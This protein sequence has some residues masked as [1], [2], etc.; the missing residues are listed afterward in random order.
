MDREE[1][2]P[3][4]SAPRDG[5]M[6]FSGYSDAQ[7]QQLRPHIDQARFPQDYARL[8]A[9]IARRERGDRGRRFAVRFTAAD[10]LAGW[11]QALAIRQPFYGAGT[12]TPGPE[13]I[14]VEGWRRTWLGL[15]QQAEAVIP[16]ARVRNVYGDQDWICFDVQR[17]AWWPRH[18]AARTGDA[19][20]AAALAGLLPATRSRWFEKQTAS[21]RDY[22]RLQRA[23]GR[24][25]LVTAVLVLASVLIYLIQAGI[26][27]YW[28]GLDRNTLINWGSNAG[29]YTVHGGWWRLVAALFLHLDPL[30]LIVNMWVLWSSGRLVERLFGNW[31]F[32]AIYFA[33]GIMGNLLSI[34]WNPAIVTVGASGAIFGVLGAYVAYLLHGD[35]RIPRPVMRAHLIPTVLF[36]FFSIL[37]G[38]GQSGIDNAAHFGG[39]GTGLLLGW[40]LARPLEGRPGGLRRAQGA[41]ALALTACAAVGL[42]LQVTGPASRPSAQEQFLQ[43][44]DWY[45]SGEARNLLAWQQIANQAGA[46]TIASADLA[47]RFRTEIIPF[48]QSTEPRLRKEVPAATPPARPFLQAVAD[49][50]AL[51][52]RWARAI[53]ASANSGSAQEAVTL[54][55]KTDAAQARLDW[56]VLRS[57]YD[58]R[59]LSL[60]AAPA[61]TLVANL[62]WFNYLPCIRSPFRDFNPVAPTDLSTDGPAQRLAL[63]CQAQRLFRM[64]DFT[65]LEAMMQDAHR[66]RGDLADGTSSYDAMLAG[67]G[68]LLDFGGLSVD[69]VFGRLAE[70][71]K[72]V[73]GSVNADLVEAEAL[74]S[75]AYAA[76]GMGFADSV[77]AQNQM[78]FQHRINIADAALQ[79]LEPRARDYPAWYAA[80]INV[81]LLGDGEEEERRA[82][83]ERARSRFPDDLA[84]SSAMLHALMPR[85]QGSFEKVAKFILEQ[86]ARAPRGDP[87]AERYARLYWL[88]AGLEGAQADIFKDAFARPEL[89]TLGMALAMKRFPKSDYL[90][91]VDG[92]LACQSDQRGEYLAFHAIMPKHYSASAWSPDFTVADCDKKFG[93]K[94]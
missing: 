92:R 94:S 2:Q 86:A 77:T 3:G 35:T 43:S 6:D 88:Y 40:A 67:L 11:L 26:S 5:A 80:A 66:L 65:N 45:R 7:L 29:S 28:L 68:N 72:A 81:N 48:W 85:W 64:R 70:W 4:A 82:I 55:Q 42:L 74:V 22:Y 69:G 93:L 76:R 46:G 39:L 15:A 31:R 19:G 14:H 44:H 38:L 41:A 16:A 83:F 27:G 62:F 91:N 90:A 84:V 51:R 56:F 34:G 60:A 8:E 18:Y 75:W 36:V 1:D 24:R 17:R 47:R 23:P 30:H 57:Q 73:P 10:G 12:I 37:N 49:F 9:E 58:H 71:R 87:Q 25:P 59:A 21:I 53:V 79:A 63:G 61:V 32:A 52:L 50:A 13:E 78:I 20:A 33:A 89:V 54:M